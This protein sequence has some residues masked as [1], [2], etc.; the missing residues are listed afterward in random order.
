[1]SATED[2]QVELRRRLAEMPLPA[3][4]G[5]FLRG[6]ENVRIEE[7]DLSTFYQGIGLMET[8]RQPGP[9][10]LA[11]YESVLRCLREDGFAVAAAASAF[12]LVDS[13]LYGFAL[14]HAKLPATTSEGMEEI[15][16]D[17]HDRSEEGDH[18]YLAELTREHVLRA[19]YDYEREFEVGLDL[20]LDGLER[21]RG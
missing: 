19:G 14:Q 17:I 20:V 13:Y 18:P 21:L 6:A 12:S 5:I 3:G 1:M 11:Y 7:N 8:R 16:A 10:A 15:A 9:R 4:Y 2:R